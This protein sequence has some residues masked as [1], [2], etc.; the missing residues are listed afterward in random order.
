MNNHESIPDDLIGPKPEEREQKTPED[1]SSDGRP[2][3]EAFLSD[4]E[5]IVISPD[6][7]HDAKNAFEMAKR[8]NPKVIEMCQRESL[9][10][11]IKS[12]KQAA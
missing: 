2:L 7:V 4:P 12:L 10:D 1:V 9:S 11:C 3:W 5:A 8:Q 6:E